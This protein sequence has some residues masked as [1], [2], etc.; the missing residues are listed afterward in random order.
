MSYCV[1]SGEVS[2]DHC[3]YVDGVRCPHLMDN[4]QIVAWINS[5]GWNATKRTAAL[6]YA[7]GITWLCKIA[8]KVLANT[9]NLR[10][11]RTNFQN[12]WN[13]DPEYVAFP[14]PQWVAVE[15]RLGLPAGSFQCSTWKGDGPASC[16]FRRT[17]AEADTYATQ[18]GMSANAVQVRKAGGR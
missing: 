1:G 6:Q 16:C 7:T 12:A 10:N 8:L 5:Q 4:A 9:P 14:R 17:T 2:G 11:N 3:C 15:Q 13:T 18:Q